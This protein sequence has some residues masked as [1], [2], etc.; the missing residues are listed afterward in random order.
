[1]DVLKKVEELI[2]SEKF[3]EAFQL[4]LSEAPDDL[5][6]VIEKSIAKPEELRKIDGFWKD[7]ALLVHF[8]YS[9]N[10]LGRE[11]DN[12]SLV[13]CVVA[14]V[15][16]IKL[17]NK[18]GIRSIAPKMMR[19]AGR[20]LSLMNMKDRAEKML[21]EAERIC[22][23]TGKIDDLLGIYNDLSALYFEGGKY[24]EA[25][26]TIEAAIKIAESR[27][28]YEAINCFSIAAEVF[29]KLGEFERAEQN[30]K[31]AETMLRE[32]VEKERSSKLEL[33]ILLSNYAI[34]CRKI[35][36]FDVAEKMFLESLGIFEELE[37]LD[38]S[39]AQFV[40]T[41]L[42]HL[43]DLY[44]ETKRFEEAEKFYSKSREKFRNIQK[45]WESFGS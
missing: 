4:V 39:F 40:A 35:G 16:A 17:A 27:N 44:R 22:M 19:N 14:S 31:K 25:K 20:A 10:I 7:V 38:F 6:P 28:D 15:N 8:S 21:L 45:R 11:N 41:N 42:R 13:S 30:Y 3:N 2:N 1:M 24:M 34:F 12:R 36:K 37:K 29:S 9:S 26:E 33:G 5:K 32:L 43:G 23:E 18:L